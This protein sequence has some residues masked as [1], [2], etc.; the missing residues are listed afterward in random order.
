MIGLNGVA[1]L[2]ESELFIKAFVSIKYC[3]V[4]AVPVSPYK[5]IVSRENKSEVHRYFLEVWS[6]SIPDGG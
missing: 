6:W 3:F 1:N 5:T 4:F 2:K